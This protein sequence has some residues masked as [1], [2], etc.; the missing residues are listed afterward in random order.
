MLSF[1][2]GNTT[3]ATLHITARVAT[4]IAD[5]GYC[6]TKDLYYH[7]LKLYALNF[8]IKQALP[9]PYRFQLTAASENDLTVLKTHLHHQLIAHACLVADKI[10]R[11]REFTSNL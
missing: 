1:M 2:N 5:K 6:S 11:S 3:N 9:L 8:S 4:Q 7:G 10:Y